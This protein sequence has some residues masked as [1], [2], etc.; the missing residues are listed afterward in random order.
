MFEIRSYNQFA[1]KLPEHQSMNSF[2]AWNQ[3]VHLCWP[4]G[5]RLHLLR[6]KWIQQHLKRLSF[7][8]WRCYQQLPAKAPAAQVWALGGAD[9]A[10]T[11]RGRGRGGAGQGRALTPQRCAEAAA[12]AAARRTAPPPRR[13]QHGGQGDSPT[14]CWWQ[15]EPGGSRVGPGAGGR[16]GEAATAAAGF[17]RG[18]G[19][20][21][22]G[23]GDGGAA[24]GEQ[25][26]NS[27]C[28]RPAQCPGGRGPGSPGRRWRWRL[29]C[30]AGAPRRSQAAR[31]WQLSP[32]RSSVPSWLRLGLSGWQG[33]PYCCLCPARRVL[34]ALW[35]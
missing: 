22:D 6:Q 18:P 33:T 3:Q 13:A 35:Q 5:A 10:L 23:C 32:A 30:G 24:P 9:A 31:R 1:A 2:G 14:R 16:R 20:G 29:F 12:A 8:L 17:P 7:G 28:P 21:A 15:E 27:R 19:N 34:S 11:R 25:Q 26:R 4:S